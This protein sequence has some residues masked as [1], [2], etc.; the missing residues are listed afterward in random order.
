VAIS[1]IGESVNEQQQP[2]TYA[3]QRQN[4]STLQYAAR[5]NQ[6]NSK[7]DGFAFSSRRNFSVGLRYAQRRTSRPLFVS[8]LPRRLRFIIFI[9]GTNKRPVDFSSTQRF[10]CC[11]KSTE[12]QDNNTANGT[13]ADW[14]WQPTLRKWLFLCAPTGPKRAGPLLPSSSSATGGWGTTTTKN[15]KPNVSVHTEREDAHWAKCNATECER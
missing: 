11:Q 7:E 12:N 13:A 4:E 9:L 5:N 6:N 15:Y 3:N 2:K 14:R 8:S 10:L 1:F